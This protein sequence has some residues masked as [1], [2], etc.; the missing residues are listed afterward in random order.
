MNDEPINASDAIGPIDQRLTDK[1]GKDE[2]F[3]LSKKMKTY[4]RVQAHHEV[5]CAEV[6]WE[7]SSFTRFRPSASASCRAWVLLVWG[8]LCMVGL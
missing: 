7:H 6:T 5:T 2:Q 3:P 1:T 4:G 8:A